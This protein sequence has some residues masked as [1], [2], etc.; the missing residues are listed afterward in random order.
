MNFNHL[1]NLLPRQTQ[2]ACFRFPVSLAES[3]K[4]HP[5]VYLVPP[6]KSVRTYWRTVTWLPKFLGWIDFQTVLMKFNYI[7]HNNRSKSMK[8]M[9]SFFFLES[10]SCVRASTFRWF[11][12][13]LQPIMFLLWNLSLT[14][15]NLS[16]L[17]FLHFVI[18]TQSYCHY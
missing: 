9:S 7:A 16:R 2:A 11:L 15:K 3:T 5:R 17:R 8:W 12:P 14:L 6:P 1:D 4:Y 13:K 18:D 10:S